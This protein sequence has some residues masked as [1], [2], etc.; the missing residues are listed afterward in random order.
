MSDAAV[1]PQG[2]PGEIINWPMLKIRY[3]TDPEAV[4]RLLPPGISPGKEPGVTITI[5]N[6]PVLNEPEYGYVVNIDADYDGIEGEYTLAIGI[7]QEAAIYGSQE[8]WGQPK[9]YADTRYF[10]MMDQVIAALT[11]RGYT[12]LEFSG[13]VT[14]PMEIPPAF[15]TNEWW[16]KCL[17]SVDMQPE[18]YDFPPHVVRVY[19]K[20]DTAYKEKIE[21][22]L[23]LNNS[24]WD[25]TASSLPVRSEPEAHLWYPTFLDRQITLAGELDGKDFWPFADTIGGSRWPGENGGPQKS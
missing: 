14:G 11:H 15:E 8:R 20:Y 4:A 5:Y 6:F 24:P 1:P 18:N 13:T 22:T 3:L 19:S 2:N 7:D 21:G 9:F 25:P 10:R 23:T 16:I 12:W 17:R